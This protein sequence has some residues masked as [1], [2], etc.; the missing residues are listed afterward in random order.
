MILEW[1]VYIVSDPERLAIYAFSYGIVSGMLIEHLR[2][3]I[4]KG[5]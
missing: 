2:S 5:Y 1:I 3:L 4:A